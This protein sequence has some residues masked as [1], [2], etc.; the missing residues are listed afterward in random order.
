MLSDIK[1]ACLGI[2]RK[3][4]DDLSDLLLDVQWRWGDIR[5][6]ASREDRWSGES[7]TSLPER[8]TI[9]PEMTDEQ[10]MMY[11]WCIASRKSLE[12]PGLSEDEDCIN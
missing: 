5:L 1:T 8:R 11:E 6:R 12:T 10:S 3:I 9:N 2:I 4:Y 7:T